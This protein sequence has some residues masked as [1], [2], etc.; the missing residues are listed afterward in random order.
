MTNNLAFLL[1]GQGSQY[2]NMA[3]EFMSQHKQ[4]KNKFDECLEYF[5]K[6]GCNLSDIWSTE[7]INQTKYTQ[8]ALFAVEYASACFWQYHGI[9]PHILIGHSIGE[10]VAAT[11]AGVISLEKACYLVTQRSKLMDAVSVDGSMLAVLA[12]REKWIHLLP[13]SI[14]VALYNAPSQ[15]VL[16]GLSNDISA[17]SATLKEAKIRSIILNVSHP[18]HSRF[19]TPCIEDFEAAIEDIPFNKPDFP[20]IGNI[21]AT[22][23][24]EYDHTYWADHIIEPVK[25]SQSIEL[26]VKLGANI[27]LECGPQPTLIKIIKNILPNETIKLYTMDKNNDP[28]KHVLEVL[29]TLSS[30]GLHVKV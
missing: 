6:F 15:I 2:P 3:N 12:P 27:F 9:T 29:K 19:M 28:E 18:F 13:T 22:V 7:Q 23:V 10:I 8:G 14:D 21:N 26:A 24:N 4:F 1:S 25:F 20:I 17:F 30:Q 11:F 5:D 16:S